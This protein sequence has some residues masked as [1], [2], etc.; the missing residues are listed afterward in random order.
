[1]NEVLK[2]EVAHSKRSTALGT[3]ICPKCGKSG[4][5]KRKTTYY[6]G[7]PS[8]TYLEIDHYK[9]LNHRDGY[10]YCCYLGVDKNDLS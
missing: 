10:A 1:M 3:I 2:R 9:T 7:K 4:Q 8:S 5:L 6:K